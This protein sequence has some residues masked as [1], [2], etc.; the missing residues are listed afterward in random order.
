[1]EDSATLPRLVGMAK[2]M[3]LSLVVAALLVLALGGWAVRAV[4]RTPIPA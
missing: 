2:I 3:L 4:R 1:M